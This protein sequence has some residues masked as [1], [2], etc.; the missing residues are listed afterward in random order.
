MVTTSRC[1]VDYV[2]T[3]YGIARLKGKTLRQR[4]RALIAIAH[5][6]FREGLAS[7]Y[8]ARFQEVFPAVPG[9]VE[10]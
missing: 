1:D 8:E 2:V 4:A 6:D 9:P 3:E 5:P 10:R 7:A